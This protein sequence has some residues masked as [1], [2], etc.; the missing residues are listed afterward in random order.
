MIGGIKMSIT[1]ANSDYLSNGVTVVPAV[2]T[3]GDRVTIMYDG[4]L[5]KSGASHIYAHVG[6]DN[7]WKN[8]H[9]HSMSRSSM[10]FEAQIPVEHADTLNICFKDCAGNWDNNSGIN[11]SFDITK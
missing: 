5:S 9:D 11:Y 3:V 6:F 1:K 8:L 7:E 4:L 2:P 10:G